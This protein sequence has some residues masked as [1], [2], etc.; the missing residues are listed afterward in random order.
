[1]RNQK[2]KNFY[3]RLSYSFGNEDWRVERKALQ[4][5]STDRVFCVTASGDR[6]LHLLL[7][8][9][10]EVVSVDLN[11]LQNYLL[12]LKVNAMKI[13]SD[14]EY[15][16][17]LGGAKDNRRLEKFDI[18]NKEL[19]SQ[20]S[21]FWQKNKKM[22]AKGVLY[23]GALEKLCQKKSAY[24][25][26]FL[27]G[28][29]VNRLFAMTTLDEQR[30]FVKNEWD[31]PVWRLA[32]KFLFN[33]PALKFLFYDPG[34][35]QNVGAA[36][37][38]AIYLPER[39]NH[40]LNSL[41]AKHNPFMSLIIRGYIEKDCYPPYLTYDGIN[42]IGKRLNKLS[43]HTD[44]AI[45]FLEKSPPQSFNCFSMSDI[46]SYMPENQFERM[47]R[48]IKRAACPNARFSIRQF[49]SDHSIPKDLAETFQ[50][51]PLLEKELEDEESCFVYR[52]MAGKV[53]G[54]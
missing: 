14:K 54:I 46:A 1:M 21:Y 32:F 39:I 16:A 53:V 45:D 22:I 17:F 19:D 48:A 31:T 11:P 34:L 2:S 51:N 29:K 10:K 6:P 3:E 49:M 27:R 20:T 30:E 13:F 52:F 47:L 5:Q 44:N 12:S 35:F 26:K 25:F 15:I 4:I 23:Q 28:N 7:D 37:N 36:I 40:S 43:W 42:E 9:C 8:E 38:P 50:R 33:T 41:L 24:A 18:L